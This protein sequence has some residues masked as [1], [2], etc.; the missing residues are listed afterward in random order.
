MAYSSSQNNHNAFNLNAMPSA[1]PE[2][3]HPYFLSPNGP[4]TVIDSVMLSDT[5]A[6]AV[7]AVVVSISNMGHICM[8]EIMKFERCTPK[9]PLCSVAQKQQKKLVKLQQENKGLKNLMDSYANGLVARSTKHDKST[10]ELQKQYEML[11]VE[12]KELASRSIPLKM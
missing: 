3:W 4:V 2:V 6:T 9:L 10:T 12:V 8:L 7:A 5:T 1:E 11:L